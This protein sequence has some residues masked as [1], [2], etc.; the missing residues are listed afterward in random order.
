MSVRFERRGPAAWV[1]FDRPQAHNAMTFAMYEELFACCERVDAAED[2]RVLVLRGA[3]GRAFVAGTDISR[4]R[5]CGS[6]NTCR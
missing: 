1:T 2:V 6:S 4:A 5:V 3:G